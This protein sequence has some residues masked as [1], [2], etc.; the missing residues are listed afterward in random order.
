MRCRSALHRTSRPWQLMDQ[1]ALLIIVFL[2]ELRIVQALR[3]YMPRL[4]ALRKVFERESF[5]I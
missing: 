2:R 5:H 4:D 3:N 1:D